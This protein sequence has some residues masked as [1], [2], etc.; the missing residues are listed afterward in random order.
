[1]LN[2]EIYN[3]KALRAECGGD[4]Y[5]ST[6]SDSEPLIN[7]Y[8]K[9]GNAFFYFFYLFLSLLLGFDFIHKLNGMFAFVMVDEEKVIVFS[10]DQGGFFIVD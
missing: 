10:L 8:R 7:L 6:N 2:G 4:S 3:H 9:Y 1:M 5:F